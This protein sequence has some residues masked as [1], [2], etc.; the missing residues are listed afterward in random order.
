MQTHCGKT[1]LLLKVPDIKIASKKKL[2]D[3]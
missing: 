1:Q 3:K 2:Q